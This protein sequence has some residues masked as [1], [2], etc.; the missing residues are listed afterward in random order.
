MHIAVP[1]NGPEEIAE[2]HQGILSLPRIRLNQ[3]DNAVNGIE[4]EMR[5]DLGSEHPHTGH[6][7]LILQGY[8]LLLPL[9]AEFEIIVCIDHKDHR[10]IGEKIKVEK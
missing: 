8:L 7:K 10:K 5:L 6:D 2:I 9:P 1:G 4:Q 3:T